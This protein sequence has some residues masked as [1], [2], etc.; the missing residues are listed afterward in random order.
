[1]RPKASQKPNKFT[2]LQNSPARVSSDGR[3]SIGPNLYQNGQRH[4][5]GWP[6]GHP[7]VKIEPPGHIADPKYTWA[8]TERIVGNIEKGGLLAENKALLRRFIMDAR[9]GKT[10]KK[11]AKKR[12]G[13]LRQA[14][15]AHDLAKLDRFFR[16]SLDTLTEADMER[17]ILALEDDRIRKG[18]GQPYA[19][20]TKVAVKKIIIKFYRWLNGGETPPLVSW[21]DTSFKLPDYHALRKEQVEAIVRLLP[22]MT[23]ELTARNRAIILFLF[24]SGARADELL[25]VRIRHLEVKDGEYRVR[26]E[27]SK[28]RPRTIALPFCREAV[29]AWL[30]LHPLRE[31]AEAQLFPLR[32]NALCNVVKRAGLVIGEKITP[33]SLRHSSATY[34]ASRLTPFQLSYRFGWS[35]SSKQPSRYIDRA[36]VDQEKVMQVA[37]GETAA[38]L[39]EQNE[40][41]HRRLAV[42]EEQ[43]NRFLEED[44][45]ELR[46]IIRI[47]KS[48]GGGA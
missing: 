1:M 43:L 30:D 3:E 24:D 29:D 23:P 13:G 48:Q 2:A 38:A 44:M 22:G 32:H 4:I 28:T 45:E 14:K 10:I 21:I 19:V 36:G 31:E 25:N 26:I 18:N 9:L 47:V 20:E 33:H 34:W 11:G 42:M 35:M 27:Y 7:P 8:T 12:V 17:F 37:Q 16:K 5:K 46:R 39:R 6:A 15:Y 41:L 40:E